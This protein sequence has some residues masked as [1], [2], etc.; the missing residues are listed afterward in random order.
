MSFFF[1]L[2]AKIVKRTNMHVG[3]PK[4]KYTIVCPRTSTSQICDYS[5]V[6]ATLCSLN[7]TLNK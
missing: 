2:L 5:Y 6:L 7:S 3:I 4:T 1:R